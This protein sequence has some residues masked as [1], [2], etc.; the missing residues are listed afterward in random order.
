[1]I[2]MSDKI[3]KIIDLTKKT[4][5]ALLGLWAVVSAIVADITIDARVARFGLA[6][7]CSSY[8]LTRKY[9]V[10]FVVS[11]FILI[12]AATLISIYK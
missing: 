2:T 10:G 11:A 9:K 6:M 4:G 8:F 7:A 3:L 12:L 1:M 5:I